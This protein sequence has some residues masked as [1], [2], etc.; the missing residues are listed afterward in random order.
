MKWVM[1]AL[2][3]GASLVT[4]AQT[5]DPRFYEIKKVHITEIPDNTP[6]RRQLFNY[7]LNQLNQGCQAKF[8][9]KRPR[10]FIDETL[11]QGQGPV[12]WTPSQ[13]IDQQP[14]DPGSGGIDI[15]I[16]GGGIGGI[17]YPGYDPV[18][19]RIINVGRVI[20]AIVDAG[21]PV[22]NFKTDVA[23]GL[24]AGLPCWS[25][26]EGWKP[27]MIKAF[28]M[29][30]ENLY[31]VNVVE[32]E[33]RVSF[34]YGGSHNG[35]GKYITHAMF[36]PKKI[37]VAWGFRFDAVATVPQVVN[38]GTKAAPIAA[39]QMN[40]NWKVTTALKNMQQGEIFYING[41]GEIKH[42]KD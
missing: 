9:A 18:L 7:S 12:P 17:G 40:M 1:V 8:K 5:R 22:V 31:G 20:W 30:Y 15:D 6:E 2:L 33:Y 42:L 41:L 34:M 19:D 27:P 10:A 21:K 29:T 39:L 35:R 11:G 14:T 26:L 23:H 4:Q 13:P 36:Q 3:L 38:Q 24:P 37:N 16:G 32:F 28:R 25:D